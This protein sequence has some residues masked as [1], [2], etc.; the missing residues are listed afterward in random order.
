M[1]WAFCIG[2]GLASGFMAGLLGIGGG[3]VIVPALVYSLPQMG[4]TGAEVPRVAIATSLA[5]IVPTAISS[6]RAHAAKQGVS[7]KALFRLTPG[8]IAGSLAGAAALSL[9]STR[10]VVVIFII[11]AFYSAWRMAGLRSKSA[12]DT[13]LE[14]LPGFFV[15]ALKGIGIGLLSS[16]V[17]VGG[18]VLSVPVMAP[19]VP[20]RTAIGTA[21]ALGLP[22]S[23]AAA[24]GYLLLVPPN[25]CSACIGYIFP[26][27][28]VAA[29]TA[30][31]LSAPL[32]AR[33]AHALPVMA[34]RRIFAAMLLFVAV[35]LT[36]KSL[37]QS[38]V[39][40]TLYRAITGF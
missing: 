13:P 12:Q 38:G 33:V 30:T 2:I 19:H 34:L 40:E 16:L 35:D 6:A 10:A 27:V 31:T 11:F 5:V 37:I 24:V 20:M 39:A 17:G 15:L 26:P 28:V 7:W 9:I 8:V 36:Y 22:I 23:L 32:G 3:V 18:G 21:A 1:I 29:G 25:G 14:P 4:V